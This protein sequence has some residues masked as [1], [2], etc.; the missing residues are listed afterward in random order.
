MLTHCVV[1]QQVS[2]CLETV[3]VNKKVDI[4]ISKHQALQILY[5]KHITFHKLPWIETHENLI[6]TKL[7]IYTVQ[8]YYYITIVNK[9][10]LIIGQ[11]ILS[12]FF[13][14]SICVI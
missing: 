6:S 9:T 7:N 4:L 11:Q 8:F 14:S 1:S 2:Y 13:S 12:K 5:L 10:Y 3:F